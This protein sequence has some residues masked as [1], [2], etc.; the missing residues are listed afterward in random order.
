VREDG[1]K[2][3]VCGSGKKCG[4]REEVTHKMGEG[5]WCENAFMWQ[6]KLGCPGELFV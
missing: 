3:R 2:M 6:W 4:E 5:G 1:V